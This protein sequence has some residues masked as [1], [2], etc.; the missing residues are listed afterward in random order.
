MKVIR[1][2][3]YPNA[4]ESEMTINNKSVDLF[5]FCVFELNNG[6]TISLH[7]MEMYNDKKDAYE[8]N[9][10]FTIDENDEEVDLGEYSLCYVEGYEFGEKFSDWFENKIPFSTKD[11]KYPTEEEE[12]CVIDY[13]EKNIKLK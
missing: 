3:N 2:H 13:Y 11:S 6:R 1:H 10:F 4:M 12:K 9:T 5:S 7:T 8:C